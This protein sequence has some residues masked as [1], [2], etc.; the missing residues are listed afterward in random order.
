MGSHLGARYSPTFTHQL[1]YRHKDH[2]QNCYHAIGDTGWD[3]LVQGIPHTCGLLIVVIDGMK[4]VV[5]LCC[6]RE[7]VC[8]F[9]LWFFCEGRR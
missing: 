8:F 5:S 3:E 4:F 2:L 6:C 9:F 1:E 7:I